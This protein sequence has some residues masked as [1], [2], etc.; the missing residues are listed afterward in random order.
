[1]KDKTIPLTAL[2]KDTFELLQSTFKTWL[3]D[4]LGLKSVS[5]ADNGRLQGVM[6]LLIEI[7]KEAKL[8][9]DF[10]TSDKIRQ[11]LAAMGINL[12]DEKDG[13]MSW[14]IE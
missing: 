13:E 10:V 5:D 7:R 14:N 8:K 12:K 6:Q 11:Q 9:K 4:V 1:M 3:E 2:S